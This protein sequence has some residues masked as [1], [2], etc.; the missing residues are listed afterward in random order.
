[1][2]AQVWQALQHNRQPGQGVV[3]T[4]HC[5]MAGGDL[6]EWSE[7]KILLGNQHALPVAMFGEE[8][9]YVALGHLHLAQ[10]VGGRER[11]RYSGSPIPMSMQERGYRHQVLL[12]EMEGEQVQE[13]TPLPVPRSVEFLKIPQQGGVTLDELLPLLA[14]LPEGQQNERSPYLEVV[15]KATTA[16]MVTRQRIE[17]ALLNKGV[18]LVKI[19]LQRPGQETVSKPFSTANLVDLAAEEIFKRKYQ[20]HYGQEPPNDW[21][22]AFHELVDAADQEEAG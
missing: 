22:A 2:Y 21:L 6:S 7:R 4:G 17:E 5:Y 13:I 14:Q 8:V 19:T 12:V 16:E 10:R 15:V 1:V 9:A 18:R 3:L 20:Q 11:V